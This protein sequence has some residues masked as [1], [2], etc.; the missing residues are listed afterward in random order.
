MNCL[1]NPKKKKKKLK[2]KK[3]K[4]K[5]IEEAYRFVSCSNLSKFLAEH[6]LF[7]NL[8]VSVV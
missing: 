5:T 8:F 1:K 2:T 6:F 7:N 4:K 3:Q